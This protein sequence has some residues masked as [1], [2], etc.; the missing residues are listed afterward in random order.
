M[1]G[2]AFSRAAYTIPET[3]AATGFGRDK[4]YKLINT[5][6]LPARKLGRRTLVL[7]SD[8]EEFLKGLPTIATAA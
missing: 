1:P 5:G 3:L 2:L 6:Q 4:L 7:A 8:L